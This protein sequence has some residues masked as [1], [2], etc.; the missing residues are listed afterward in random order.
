VDGAVGIEALTAVPGGRVFAAGYTGGALLAFDNRLR[1]DQSGDRP[2]PIGLGI[3]RSFDA[4]WDPVSGGWAMQGL[5]RTAQEFVATVTPTLD[6]KTSLFQIPG[7]STGLT[8]L[9][10]GS[11]AVCK[12]GR[13]EI[14]HYSRSGALLGTI[15][16][17]AAGLPPRRCTT[18]AYLP[19]LDAYA[20][21][22]ARRPLDVFV[23][24]AGGTS[25]GS[26]T[27]SAPIATVAAAPDG[28]GDDV[29]AWEP[30]TSTLETFHAPDGALLSQRAL[31]VG[32]I[33]APFGFAAGPGGTY[34]LLD[35]NDSELAVFSP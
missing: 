29:L 20:V 6:S 27:A 14:D 15:D 31:D 4:V 22:L 33:I 26:F 30:M 13:R 24:S 21:N 28:P 34:A 32:P 12:L 2:F 19:A 7:L 11:F 23:V 17:V 8:E 18:L 3:S 9:P 35:G 16:L 10:D 5:D 1:R 25:L